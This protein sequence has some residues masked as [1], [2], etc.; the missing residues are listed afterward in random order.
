MHH[1]RF[2]QRSTDFK[3]LKVADHIDS[4]DRNSSPGMDIDEAD[5]FQT[6]DRFAYGRPTHLKYFTKLALRDQF[7]R[8][9][10]SANDH[11]LDLFECTISQRLRSLP[12]LLCFHRANHLSLS[13]PKFRSR[14][15]A[16]GSLT[17]PL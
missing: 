7:A 2:L 10:G 12:H 6:C 8:R 13:L 9:K 1:N 17:R 14:V 11:F 4:R 15:A 16:T 3:H 5:K